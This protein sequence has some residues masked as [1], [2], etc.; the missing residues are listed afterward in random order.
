[1]DG[2][3][4]ELRIVVGAAS[5]AGGRSG[6]E[7]AVYLGPLTGSD[8]SS[9]DAQA[10]FL[11]AVADGMGGHRG[12]EVASKLA[13]DTIQTAF[14][15]VPGGDLALLL[16]QAFRQANEAI[17]ERGQAN[18]E[19]AMGTTL[20]VAVIRGKYATIAS[21]GDSRAYLARA[22]RLNQI[23]K[24]HSFVAEQVSRGAMSEAQARQ[25]A[26]RNIL[27]HA[28]GHRPKLE[29]K[30]PSVFEITLLAEDRLVLCTDGFYDVLE[31]DEM[32]RM[33]LAHE[34]PEAARELVGAAVQRG[35]TDNVSA[36]VAAAM[37]TRV[38]QRE[39]VAVEGAGGRSLLA[40][41]LVA[42]AAIV[43]IALVLLALLVA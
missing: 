41:V 6:N 11:L 25:S 17:Y 35:A 4:S 24:D 8:A 42:I 30:L 13:I 33:V 27:T 14:S 9:P 43:F 39:L 38:R 36:V 18:G 1:V 5:D 7:D 21:V 32:L 19:E 3:E 37:P 15:G 26:Q 29:T 10:D 16:K 2:A 34:P 22:N 20:V 31:E 12:G 23:T 40:P 28:L